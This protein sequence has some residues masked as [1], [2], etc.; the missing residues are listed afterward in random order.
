LTSRERFSNTG[1]TLQARV[2]AINEPRK[3]GK[4]ERSCS[5]HHKRSC[6]TPVSTYRDQKASQEEGARLALD[7]ELQ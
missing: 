4:M 5:L 3:Q 6:D 7:F 1:S 2:T